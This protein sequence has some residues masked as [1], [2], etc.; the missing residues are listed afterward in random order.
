[1]NQRRLWPDTLE[2]YVERALPILIQV[3]KR[4]TVITYAELMNRLDGGPGRAY[5]GEVIGRISE[6]ELEAGRP[7]LSAVVVRSD[8]RMVGGGFFGFPDTPQIIRRLVPEEWQNHYLSEADEEHWQG[9]LEEVYRYW[10]EH[11]P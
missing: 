8:T 3:A 2:A 10:Q 11:D 5:I 9:Q 1:M 6:I 7:K 4:R